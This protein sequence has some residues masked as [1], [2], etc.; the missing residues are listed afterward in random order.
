MLI[1]LGKLSSST[2]PATR[3]CKGETVD[4]E[5]FHGTAAMIEVEDRTQVSPPGRE[6]CFIDFCFLLGLRDRF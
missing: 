6:G 4:W 1:K 5:D 3:E 2:K